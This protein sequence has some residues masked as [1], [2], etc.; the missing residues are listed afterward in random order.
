MWGN[1]ESVKNDLLTMADYC[2]YKFLAHAEGCSYSGRLKYL[3]ACNSVIVAH[4]L[5][6]V[7]HHHPLMVS[8]GLEQNFVEVK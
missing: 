4:K 3:Q 7:Q 1:P 5:D 6:W 2:R 8:E